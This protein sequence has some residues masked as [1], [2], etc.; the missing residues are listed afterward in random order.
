MRI[1]EASS[2]GGDD[3]QVNLMP[4]IDM[5]FLLLIFFLVATTIAN[6]ERDRKIKLA[7]TGAPQA[8][9]DPPQMVVINIRENGDMVVNGEQK[10]KEQLAGILRKAKDASP[11]RDVLIRADLESR[12]KYF[13]EV[14]D[15]CHNVGVAAINIG[16]VHDPS[17][18]D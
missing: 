17:K 14:V 16:Y 15:V 9:S 1:L 2:S 4:L 3:E 12:H 10:S 8:L 6:D 18:I 13:A 5:V 11:P 7:I